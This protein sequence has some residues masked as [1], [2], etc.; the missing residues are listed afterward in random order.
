MVAPMQTVDQSGSPTTIEAERFV[1]GSSGLFRT[2]ILAHG[3]N[4]G[5][6]RL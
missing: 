1:G 5:S 2:G 4:G 3:L 6:G